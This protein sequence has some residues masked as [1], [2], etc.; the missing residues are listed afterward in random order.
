MPVFY[1]SQLYILE[2]VFKFVGLDRQ[3]M[4]VEENHKGLV[5]LEAGLYLVDFL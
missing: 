4:R 2:F 3:E 5:Q 1:I